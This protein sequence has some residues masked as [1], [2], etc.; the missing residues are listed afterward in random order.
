MQSIRILQSWNCV[1]KDCKVAKIIDI[2]MLRCWGRAE[3]G[4]NKA[5]KSR[6]PSV[7]T[8]CCPTDSLLPAGRKTCLQVA[9]LIG[10]PV[11]SAFALLSQKVTKA[12]RRI[13]CLLPDKGERKIY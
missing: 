6:P 9:F 11:K 5:A 12:M 3:S 8:V 4:G 2:A 1:L 7:R 13:R 10:L